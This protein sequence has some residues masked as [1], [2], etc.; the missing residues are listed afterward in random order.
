MRATVYITVDVENS[1]G[2][3]WNNANLHP[4]GA[5]R[6]IY[7]YIDGR[8]HGIGWICDA[9]NA[10][11][12]KA[13]FFAEIFGSLVFG[14]NET[15]E[16]ISYLLDRG[17]DVQLHTHLNFYFFSQGALVRPDDDAF[18]DNLADIAEPLRH[19]LLGKARDIFR[20]LTGYEPLAYRAGN[21]RADRALLRDLKAIGIV[22]DAS[23]NQALQGSGSFDEGLGPVNA[24]QLVDGIWELPVAVAYQSLPTLDTIGS[25]RPL[26]PFSMSC[27]E[28]RKVLDYL[29]V[30]GATH[31]SIAF[32]SF[33][34]VRAK[35]LQYTKLM[36]NHV[37]Q[38]R[39][40]FLLDYLAAHQD[41][42]RVSTV[43]ELARQLRE[44]PISETCH[45]ILPRLGL[46]RPL[47]REMRRMVNSVYY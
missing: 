9:L 2:G 46:F 35:D 31:I 25:L 15:R 41:R 5:D 18:S 14:D 13:T 29:H 37:V 40:E 26:D 12:L 28:M 22:V 20:R 10:R 38:R 24:L 16:W 44:R 23:F 34:G 32:H 3:A 42:F 47:L 21:W 45:P 4:V 6:R 27:L 36:P 8:S 11:N 7:C 33:S 1:M 17:Q 19:E 43:G 39:F 30:S